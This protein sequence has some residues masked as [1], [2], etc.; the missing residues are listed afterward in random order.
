[1][2]A[3]YTLIDKNKYGV[4]NPEEPCNRCALNKSE[5]CTIKDMAA[6]YMRAGIDTK[7]FFDCYCSTNYPMNAYFEELHQRIEKPGFIMYMDDDSKFV[8]EHAVMEIM[9]HV[10]SKDQMTIWQACI[11]M[12]TPTPYGKYW[13]NIQM[14]GIDTST[15]MFHTNYV[16]DTRWRMGVRCGDFWTASS[17][18]KAL[19]QQEWI[20]NVF[21]QSQ[22]G[23]FGYGL[24][25]DKAQVQK[26]EN[27]ERCLKFAHY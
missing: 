12:Q 8:H 20:H 14:G 1:M 15:F 16:N 17:L 10:S 21:I 9:A 3:D 11:T 19:P 18:G 6:A 2:D 22:S 7:K 23:Q 4:F 26:G 5:G 13:G 25:A 27:L 24:R